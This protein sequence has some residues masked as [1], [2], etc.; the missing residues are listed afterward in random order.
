MSVV[1]AGSFFC[2]SIPSGKI[3]HSCSFGCVDRTARLRRMVAV[4]KAEA[5]GGVNINPDIR[6]TEDKVVDSVDLTQL[7]KPLTAYCR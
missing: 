4:V 3:N 7:S 1:G 5:E 2:P 6:K